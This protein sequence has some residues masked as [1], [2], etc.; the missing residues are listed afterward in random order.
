MESRMRT[1]IVGLGSAGHTL[2]IPALRRIPSV[3]I[4]GACDLDPGYRARAESSWGIRTFDDYGIMLAQVKP[5]LVVIGTPPHSH[6]EFCIMAL[7]AGADVICEKPFVTSLIEGE[8][9]LAAAERTGRSV[10]VN[11]EFREMPI[12]QAIRQRVGSPGIGDLRVVQ[13]WQLMDMAPWEESGWRGR[14]RHRTIFEA[15]VHLI[16]L[17]MALFEEKPTAVTASTTSAGAHPSEVDAVAV[18]T[19]EFSRGRIAHLSQNRLCKG[20]R[21]YFE[22]RADCADASLRASFG[23]RARV[24]A[25]LFR[26]S[27]PHIRAELGVSGIAWVEQGTRRKRIA[28]NPRDPGGKATQSVFEDTIDA[29]RSC[30]APPTSAE[31]ALETLEVTAAAYLSAAEGR[32][33]RLDGDT[34]QTLR[35]FRMGDSSC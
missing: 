18:V 20:E 24:S 26:S 27:R 14:L 29:F 22:V 8:G 28:R 5:D 2:H 21:Q 35:E 23:G 10:A 6:A 12:F 34:A 4:D 7:E 30:R 25:G 9:V 15:G 11:H 3:S 32:R 33:I 1:A 31:F 13:M 17:A 19:L 16:D